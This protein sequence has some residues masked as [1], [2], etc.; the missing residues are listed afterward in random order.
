[1]LP[2]CKPCAVLVLVI[3]IIII[4]SIWFGAGWQNDECMA[5]LILQIAKDM[6]SEQKFD[7][8]CCEKPMLWVFYGHQTYVFCVLVFLTYDKTRYY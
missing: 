2:C 5:A 8:I 4:A 7:M 3:I 6:T 1:M